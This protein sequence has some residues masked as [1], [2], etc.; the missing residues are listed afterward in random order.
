[1]KIQQDKRLHFLG[2]AIIALTGSIIFNPLIGLWLGVLA[3]IAKEA[4]YD[5]FMGLGC[6]DMWDF[7]ATSLGSV[8]GAMLAL[9]VL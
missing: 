9:V 8:L 4:I 7:I 3:G 1:M 6:P 5:D 2:G